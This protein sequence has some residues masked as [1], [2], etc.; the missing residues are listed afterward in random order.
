MRPEPARIPKTLVGLVAGLVGAKLVLV[1]LVQ[2]EDQALDHVEDFLVGLLGER[3][4]AGL[5]LG[6]SGVGP[7]PKGFRPQ[8]ASVCLLR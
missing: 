1:D 4:K 7:A 5:E 6:E 8:D 2:R 3:V